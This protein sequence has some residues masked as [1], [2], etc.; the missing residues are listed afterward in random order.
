MK[1]NQSSFILF[2][3]DDGKISVDIRFEG[4]TVRLSQ[5]QM[6][7]RKFRITTNHG[8]IQA[9]LLKSPPDKFSFQPF[10]RASS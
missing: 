4:E 5:E 6:A 1:N 9:E 2:K 8:A 7:V 3:T 10:K